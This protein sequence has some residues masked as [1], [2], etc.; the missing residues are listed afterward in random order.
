MKL[1]WREAK[2]GMA[3]LLGSRQGRSKAIDMRF[4]WLADRVQQGQFNEY[5]DS[6]K[7]NL[8]DYFTKH[9]PPSHR[10]QVRPIY[11]A[12][13]VPSSPQGTMAGRSNTTIV[14]ASQPRI[15]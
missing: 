12:P 5:W 1:G 8:V 3:L 2:L 4:Y 11:V 10:R 15:P 14:V 6:G 13:V 9:H 7:K